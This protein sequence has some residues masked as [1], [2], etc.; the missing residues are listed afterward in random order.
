MWGNGDWNDLHYVV[1]DYHYSE[2]AAPKPKALEEMIRDAAILSK[3]LDYARIDLY[4]L[5]GRVVFGEV[6]L[7][8]MGGWLSYFTPEANKLMGDIIRENLKKQGRK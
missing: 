6:T 1:Q 8:P 7:T 5:D 4:D 2:E 3:G